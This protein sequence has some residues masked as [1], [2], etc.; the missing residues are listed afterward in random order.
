MCT[1][2]PSSPRDIRRLELLHCIYGGLADDHHVG[3]F[4]FHSLLTHSSS[5]QHSIGFARD[6]PAAYSCILTRTPQVCSLNVATSVLVYINQPRW[7]AL[8][9]KTNYAGDGVGKPAFASAPGS[10]AGGAVPYQKWGGFDTRA[11]PGTSTLVTIWVPSLRFGDSVR[12]R[13][14]GGRAKGLDQAAK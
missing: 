2:S 6:D 4:L 14:A 13:I 11:E 8:D 12:Q 10:A 9:S 5:S 7:K 3:N 1:L